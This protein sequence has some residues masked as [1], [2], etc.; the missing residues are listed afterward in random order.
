MAQL[1]KATLM[2]MTMVVIST[3]ALSTDYIVGDGSGW[4]LNFNYT[5]WA[6]GK[7]FHVGDRLIFRY[8][9]GSHNVFRLTTA[10]DFRQ[11]AVPSNVTSLSSG[12]DVIVLASPG[13]KWYICGFADH[14]TRG[15]KLAIT[16]TTA[17]LAPS[18]SPAS[19]GVSAASGFSGS[20]QGAW[21]LA[22]TSLAA[23]KMIWA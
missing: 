19:P 9:E 2:V 6:E 7:D 16:V 23:Y 13:R 8:T 20:M 17:D 10:D 11:C 3:P 22:A 12:N 15:M 5:A 1:L 18:P 4:K 21:V 14:C